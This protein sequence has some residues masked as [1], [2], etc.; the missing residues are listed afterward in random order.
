MS[1]CIPAEQPGT[2]DRGLQTAVRKAGGEG[3]GFEIGSELTARYRQAVGG[4]RAKMRRGE[5]GKH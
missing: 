5:A 4:S 2:P 1:N 3:K